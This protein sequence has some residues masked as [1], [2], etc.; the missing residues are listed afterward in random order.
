MASFG[1]MA[2]TMG[3]WRVVVSVGWIA[4]AMP[5]AAWGTV[6]VASDSKVVVAPKVSLKAYAFGLED[7]RLLDGPFKRAMERDAAYLLTLEPDRLL[8]RFRLYAG[9]E[10]RAPLYGGW[11]TQG[12]SGHSLGHYLSACSM[13]YASTGNEQ[14][15]S[16]VNYIVDELEACQN[17]N[18]NGYVGGGKRGSRLHYS[19]SLFEP[20]TS[21]TST[22]KW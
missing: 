7:V 20:V 11:E 18:G 21:I 15:R 1:E 3:L 17:A 14:F 16:R 2:G 22:G 13:M 12:V 9:L 5:T 19:L 4:A 8:H 6:P 10:P